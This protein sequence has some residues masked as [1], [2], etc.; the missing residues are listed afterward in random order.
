MSFKFTY[1]ELH[2]VPVWQPPKPSVSLPQTVSDKQSL[3]VS[4]LVNHSG[5]EGNIYEIQISRSENHTVIYNVST[6]GFVVWISCCLKALYSCILVVLWY[7]LSLLTFNSLFYGGDV[8][9]HYYFPLFLL[10]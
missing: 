3:L 5:L 2:C 4:W 10:I 8:D 6:E 9:N 7:S 1:I